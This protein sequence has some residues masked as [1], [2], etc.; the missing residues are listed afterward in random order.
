MTHHLICVVKL[1]CNLHLCAQLLH[2]PANELVLIVLLVGWL[3]LIVFCQINVTSPLSLCPSGCLL[4][5]RFDTLF[6]L[7][8]RKTKPKPAV[9]IRHHCCVWVQ[10]RRSVG[11]WFITTQCVLVC[12]GVCRH[13]SVFCVNDCIFSVCARAGGG[14]PSQYSPCLEH[15]LLIPLLPGKWGYKYLQHIKA[16]MTWHTRAHAETPKQTWMHGRLCRCAQERASAHVKSKEEK[17]VFMM[18]LAPQSWVRKLMLPLCWEKLPSFRRWV[19]SAIGFCPRQDTEKVHIGSDVLGQFAALP[20]AAK[21]KF[22][23]HSGLHW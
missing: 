13:A 11:E 17:R 5:V 14:R 1:L 20:A 23:L 18:P 8:M 2:Y 9:I 21:L 3:L 7:W 15:R 19:M 10:L 12:V 6:C 16:L 4:T 22:S